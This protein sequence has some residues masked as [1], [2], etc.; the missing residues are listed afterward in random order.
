MTQTEQ[1]DSRVKHG[2]CERF[3]IF[4]AAPHKGNVC[5][6]RDVHDSFTRSTSAVSCVFPPFS[7][8]LLNIGEDESPSS[9]QSIVPK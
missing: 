9:F 6:Q 5:D 8:N 2:F 1:G 3:C 4:F 7:K